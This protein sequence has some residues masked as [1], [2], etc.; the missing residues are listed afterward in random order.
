MSIE[1]CIIK[2]VVYALRITH[3]LQQQQKLIAK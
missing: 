1:N 3:I 2:R